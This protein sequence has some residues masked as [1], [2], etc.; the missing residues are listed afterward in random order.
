[1]VGVT[2]VRFNTG[3]WDA[4]NST[5]NVRI[6]EYRMGDVKLNEKVLDFCLLP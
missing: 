1:M 4:E 3:N 2:Q 6:S 5:G